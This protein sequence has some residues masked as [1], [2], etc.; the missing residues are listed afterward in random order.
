MYHLFDVQGCKLKDFLVQA[1]YWVNL[2]LLSN[3]VLA[4]LE[5]GFDVE[6]G[7]ADELGLH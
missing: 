7:L 2:D 5:K 6:V 3:L 4:L 1:C